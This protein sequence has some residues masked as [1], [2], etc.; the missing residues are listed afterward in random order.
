[1]LHKYGYLCVLSFDIKMYIGITI[2][3][4]HVAKV[5]VPRKILVHT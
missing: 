3:K 5:G 1:M 4:L 2:K